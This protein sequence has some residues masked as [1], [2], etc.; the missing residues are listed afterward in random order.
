MGRKPTKNLNLP[1]RMRARVRGKVTYYFFDTGEKPRREIPLGKVY[2]EAVRRWADLSKS[3]RTT[4]EIVTFR[5]TAE[6]FQREVVPTKAPKTQVEYNAAVAKLLLFFDDPPGPLDAIKPLHVRQYLDWR[7]K[8]PVSADREVAVL[9]A[10]WN[11]AREWGLTDSANPCAGVKRH[12]KPGRDVYVEDDAYRAVWDAADQPLRDALDL[13]YLTGQ[14]PA[15]VRTLSLTDVRDGTIH[16]RQGKTKRKVR[17]EVGGEL[18]VL[19]KRISARR[20]DESETGRVV[21]AL[22]LILDEK[23]QPMGPWKLRGRFDRARTA[24]AAKARLDGKDLLAVAIEGFQFRDLRAK[25]GTDKA[26]ASGV[27]DA[28]RQLGHAS[29]TMTEHYIRSRRGQKVT[30]TK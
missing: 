19:L 8:K 16:V 5:Q 11:R 3:S 12:N 25:A 14:R 27:F 21:H 18:D 29:V 1:S 2:S 30:P 24:A 17:I 10:I 15:D 22:N 20:K 26:D 9:S 28:Q 4:G 13:A 7:R 23:G 6:R